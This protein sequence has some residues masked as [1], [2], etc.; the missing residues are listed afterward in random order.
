[1]RRFVFVF[2]FLLS[3]VCMGH[4]QNEPSLRKV[5]DIIIY[6]DSTFYS[7]FPS[8]VKKENGELLVAFRR[9]PDRKIFKEKGSNH[10]DPNS[11]LV[12]VRYLDNG[13][14]WSRPELIYAH[15]CSGSLH[16]C[17]VLLTIAAKMF[18]Y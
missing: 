3:C 1:M 12:L 7:A 5:K 13:H 11:Y 18:T 10:V 14:T 17:L 8:V 2:C 4:S 9:A 15:P 16:P 6:E